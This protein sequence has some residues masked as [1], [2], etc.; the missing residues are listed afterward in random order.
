VEVSL[1][2]D[3]VHLRE[4]RPFSFAL[5]TQ[6]AE[7]IRWYL[8]DYRVYPV[9]PTPKTA[10]RIEQR[11]GEIGRELFQLVLAGSDVWEAVRGRL[12]DTRIEIETELEDALV[13]WELIRDPVADL[14]LALAVPA[15]VRCHSKPAL[16]PNPPAPATGK[17]RI[18]LAICRLE[19]DKVPFRSVAR[20]LI[21]GLSGEAREP[22][23]LEVLRPATFEQLAKRLRAAKAK[24]EPFHAVHFDGHG[25]AGEIF[26]EN[27]NLKRDRESVKAAQLGK[28]LHETGVPLLILNACRSAYSEP[29]EM[30]QTDL[31]E[32]IRQFGSFAHSVMDSGASG[33]VAWRYSVFV[34][35]AAQF[36]ADLYASLASGLPLGEAATFARKG[37]QSG[38]R[39]IEDWTVPVVFEAAP[40]RL[41]PQG[42]EGFAIKLQA[43]GPADS[44]LPQA[45]DVG[46]I[47]Q[48][49]SILRLDRTFDEQNI[50][51]L[52]AYAGSGK[53]STAAEFVNW[54]R[55]TGGLGLSGRVLFT[56][57]GQHKRLPQVLDELGRVFE[58]VLAKD[59]IQWLTLDD[60]QR[61]KVSLQV[62]GRFPVL[63][64]WDNVEPIAGFPAGTPSAWSDGEQN[65]LADFLR[66]ARATRAKFL[67]TSRRDERDWLHDLPARIELP[68]MPIEESV[69][70]IRELAK[71]FGRRLDDVADWRPLIDFAL[72]NPMTLTVLAGQALREGL[73]TRDQV[74]SLI[75]KIQAGEDVF[76]D[77]ASEGRTRSLAASLA[78]GFENAFSGA[79][80]RQTALLHLFQ[81]FVAVDVL[82][83]MGAPE[84]EWCLAAV[85]GLTRESGIALLNRAA[86]VGLLTALGGGYY[87]IHPALPW[88]LRRL[89]EQ[90]YPETRTAATRA[91]VEAMGQLGEHCLRQYVTGNGDIIGLLAE[92]EANLLC[93]RK[94]ARLNG[95][96]RSVI[97]T[98]QGLRV[99]YSHTG[100]LAG[101]SRLV[102]EILPDFIDPGA[103]GPVYG[104]EEEWPLVTE[105]RARMARDARRWGEAER[106]DVAR[107][108]WNR[109]RAA[110]V[111][112]KQPQDRDAPENNV[113]RALAGALHDLSQIRR[114]QG[115]ATCVQSSQ[116]ALI[117]AEA[118][119]DPQLAG[120]CAFTL[121]QAYESLEGIR[122][123]ALAEVWYRRSL[124]L[125]AKE[126]RMGRAA[127]LAQLGSVAF[128]RFRK[129]RG[130]PMESLSHLS[131]AERDYL[132]ALETF[133]AEA[134]R[135]RATVHSQLGNVYMAAGR[136]DVALGQYTESVRYSEAIDGRFGAG[137]TRHNAAVTLAGVGRF[138]DAH[139]W[140]QAALRDFEA[141]EN[142]E[143]YVVEALKLLEQIESARQA[144]SPPS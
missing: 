141:T 36:M 129:S 91:F 49:E 143:R 126:D 123:L 24:G 118:I 130:S 113:L 65:E 5:S 77:E 38:G 47:G 63:W 98:M 105:Y 27:A 59:E 20:H 62:L 43:G 66:A 79:E 40:V 96:W 30:P 57:F 86:E 125:C 72:G 8:E 82:A 131:S 112:A 11:M 31:H 94:L 83:L 117:L 41:F 93:A 85:R 76:E 139:D 140:A 42:Q 44:A 84:E 3:G 35:T 144:T 21:R 28:L 55:Q 103:D 14:P 108:E 102:E 32:R 122:D 33:V 50:V 136:I 9:E 138:A 92:E 121:G 124:E 80:R 7:N 58:K 1:E 104:R 127:C 71:K 142:A 88:F 48:D 120:I 107:I 128:E 4:T 29:L 73:R 134:T 100:R 37:L 56:S 15:F 60:P 10:K 133:P 34:D 110:T 95:W 68:S 23:D 106:L 75:H 137:L 116:E 111:L 132:L 52:H 6:E 109:Q 87:R 26:F 74:V 135:E 99:L 78:Y 89:F 70:M 81:G 39:D 114:E 54:Y 119:G 67:L 2:S 90:H 22:F 12:A 61:R 101:W 97:G 17:I 69:Q 18:L 115:S 51:L 64:F 13:P 25:D 45:P 46:F 53:T 16:K 19:D